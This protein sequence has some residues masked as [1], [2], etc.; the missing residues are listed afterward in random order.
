MTIDTTV[1]VTTTALLGGL[2]LGRL[3]QDE[4]SAEHQP[5]AIPIPV[6][7]REGR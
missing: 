3:K 7:T 5:E 2:I 6:K 1:V 4:Q